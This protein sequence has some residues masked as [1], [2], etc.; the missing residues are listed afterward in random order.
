MALFLVQVAVH[1]EQVD[2]FVWKLGFGFFEPRVPQC[3]LK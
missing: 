2:I 3:D 1:K